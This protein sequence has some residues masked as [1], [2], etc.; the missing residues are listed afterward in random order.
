MKAT[1][2]N[3]S[4]VKICDDLRLY[5]FDLQFEAT[6][7]LFLDEVCMNYQL[8]PSEPYLKSYLIGMVVKYG[9]D[10]WCV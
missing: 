6:I 4:C 1:E 7:S 10:V 5:Q 8:L 2:I 9:L 3:G